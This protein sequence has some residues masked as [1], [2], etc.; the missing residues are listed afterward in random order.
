MFYVIWVLLIMVYLN[1]HVH[2]KGIVFCSYI[3]FC[4]YQIKVV[5]SGVQNIYVFTF[6]NPTWLLRGG[7]KSPA[8]TKIT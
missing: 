3:V 2:L 5:D 8:L 6:F 4:K 7:L 1:E